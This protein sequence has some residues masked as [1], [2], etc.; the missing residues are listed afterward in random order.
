MVRGGQ[1]Q[2]SQPSHSGLWRWAG[3]MRLARLGRGPEFPE[4]PGP[5]RREGE[6]QPGSRGAG[7]VMSDLRRHLGKREFQGQQGNGSPEA[8]ERE[9]GGRL[10]CS[11][12][13]RLQAAA[14]G[15]GRCCVSPRRPTYREWG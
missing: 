2:R 15:E 13:L 9:P 14:R 7:A 5:A 4:A 8:E 10:A 1:A 12:A 11:E 6:R 3:R